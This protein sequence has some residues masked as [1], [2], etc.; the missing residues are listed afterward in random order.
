MANAIFRV[1]FRYILEIPF[2]IYGG[3]FIKTFTAPILF[4]IRKNNFK[5]RTDTVINYL[6]DFRVWVRRSGGT[7]FGQFVSQVISRNS[8]IS[9]IFTGPNFVIIFSK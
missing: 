4:N 1:F 3:P 8:L 6:V 9:K 2:F 7:G 5:N